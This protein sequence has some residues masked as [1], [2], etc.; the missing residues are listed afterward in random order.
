MEEPA[1]QASQEQWKFFMEFPFSQRVQNVFVNAEINSID[2]LTKTNAQEICKYRNVGRLAVM[3]IRLALA[4]MNLS[5]DGEPVYK[6]P[7]LI[8][9]DQLKERLMAL[10]QRRDEILVQ[11]QQLKAQIGTQKS[12]RRKPQKNPDLDKKILA[13]WKEMQDYKIIA[14]EFGVT[15]NKVRAVVVGRF[16]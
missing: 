2:R 4:R 7:E 1:N 8:E 13:R 12:L 10:E 14:E 11:I 3:E 9:T 15:M 6:L 16:A 5:L